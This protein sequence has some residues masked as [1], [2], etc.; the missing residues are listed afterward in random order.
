MSRPNGRQA[1][2]YDDGQT[3]QDHGRR[4]GGRRG[5]RRAVLPRAEEEQLE[6]QR[7]R[8]RCRGLVIGFR[9]PQGVHIADGKARRRRRLPWWPPRA[10][11]TRSCR[12]RRGGGN[13]LGEPDRGPSSTPTSAPRPAAGSSPA[14][15]SHSVAGA[16]HHRHHGLGQLRR[17][18]GQ[19]GAPGQHHRNRHPGH[20]H[21]QQG[22]LRHL[23]QQ[24]L[25]DCR[26]SVHRLL[27][28]S[29][30]PAKAVHASAV[31]PFGVNLGDCAAC[32][33]G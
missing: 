20:E 4:A 27:T 8:T 1:T 25:R 10:P 32:C 5:R 18:L 6:R 33:A 28:R 16:Q 24:A 12:C 3:F 9:R 13:G 31:P 2:R 29:G 30:S 26:G 22:R 17:R 11:A 14:T 15:G 19:V 21:R 23:Q 7:E